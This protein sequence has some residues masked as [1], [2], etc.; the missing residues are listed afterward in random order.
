GPHIH[1][2]CYCYH[3]RLLHHH[4]LHH[5]LHLR[6]W[7][8]NGGHGNLL[9]HHRSLRHRLHHSP[10]HP[11]IHFLRHHHHRHN[12]YCHNLHRHN[13]PRSP[14]LFSV[15]S[16]HE[17]IARPVVQGDVFFQDP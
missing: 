9:A 8:R 10:G 3:H 7:R 1:F 5:H 11:H 4:S 14:L 13:L 12:H 15:R 16:C 6:S 17:T 2:S